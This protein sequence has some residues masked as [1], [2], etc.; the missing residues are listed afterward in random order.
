MLH[1]KSVVI[2]LSRQ[3]R[4]KSSKKLRFDAAVQK[5][6]DEAMEFIEPDKS[7]L[8]KRPFTFEVHRM[9]SQRRFKRTLTAESIS[10]EHSKMR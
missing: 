7:R 3:A 4:Q 1:S 10:V 8:S 9:I 5:I 2:N 6:V